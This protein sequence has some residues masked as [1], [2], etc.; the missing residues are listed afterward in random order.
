MACLCPCGGDGVQETEVA[1]SP[2]TDVA[3]GLPCASSGVFS[4][5]EE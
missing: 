1:S 2:G 5:W 4:L 3:A